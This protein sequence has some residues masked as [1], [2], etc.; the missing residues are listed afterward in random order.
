MRGPSEF[1]LE[2]RCLAEGGAHGAL[3]TLVAGAEVACQSFVSLCGLF[4]AD[5]PA[6]SRLLTYEGTL[7]SPPTSRIT[8]RLEITFSNLTGGGAVLS[9][10]RI[11]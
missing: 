5:G 4:K 11:P 6:G 7:L 3:L 2:S 9:T 1:E 8:D 10:T